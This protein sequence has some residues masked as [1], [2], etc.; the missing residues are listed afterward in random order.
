MCHM[1]AIPVED[2]QPQQHGELGSG[3][4]MHEEQWLGRQPGAGAGPR[5]VETA[6][7]RGIEGQK[8]WRVVEDK[9]ELKKETHSYAERQ[10][11][12]ELSEEG[13]RANWVEGVEY[14]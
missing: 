1:D 10:A 4:R 3:R 13:K 9:M 2:R 11:T 5:S 12:N 7:G 14:R 6:S 8:G